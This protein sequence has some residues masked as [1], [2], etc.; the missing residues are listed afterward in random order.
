MPGADGKLNRH[1]VLYC[2]LCVVVIGVSLLSQ[3]MSLNSTYHLS[4]ITKVLWGTLLAYTLLR[5]K[6][7]VCVASYA[8]WMIVTICVVVIINLIQ[9]KSITFGYATILLTAFLIYF[10]SF[11]L[12]SLYNRKIVESTTAHM[13][14]YFYGAVVFTGLTATTAYSSYSEWLNSMQY[15]SADA[16]KNSAGQI[17]AVAILVGVFYLKFSKVILNVLRWLCVGFLIFGMFALQCRGAAIALVI[18]LFISY[19]LFWSDRKIYGVVAAIVLIIIGYCLMQIPE[20]SQAVLKFLGI[21]KYGITDANALSSG[22]V[23]LW[24]AALEEFSN[25]I[26]IGNEEYYV[27]NFFISVLVC[28]GIVGAAFIYPLYGWRIVHNLRAKQIGNINKRMLT[29]YKC[30]SIFYIIEPIFEG[31]PPFGPGVA[32]ML[33]WIM[34]GYFDAL[35]YME[36]G[37]EMIEFK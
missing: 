31:G 26:L 17:L 7:V 33:F 20:V 19:F 13:D 32:C 2:L 5:M 36:P 8:R 34:N 21:T 12:T 24:A 28:L 1:K 35:G 14:I 6:F 9:G 27:D 4:A 25:H 22:R 37:K 16:G 23:E 30:L 11:S 18:A 3:V 29:L 15:V 10:T